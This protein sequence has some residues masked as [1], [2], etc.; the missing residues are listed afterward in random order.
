MKVSPIRFVRSSRS[1][2]KNQAGSFK[3]SSIPN[4][5]QEETQDKK[6][7]KVKK[8][9]NSIPKSILLVSS[10]ALG[11]LGGYLLANKKGGQANINKIAKEQENTWLA[12]LALGGIAGYE[13]KKLSK[14]D[15]EE[16]IEKFQTEQTPLQ[17]SINAIK[18]KNEKLSDG[19]INPAVFKY[20]KE[21]HGL[22]LLTQDNV[23]NKNSQKYDKAIEEIKNVAFEKLTS[24]EPL[25]PLEKQNPVFWSATSEFAPVKEGGL[26]SVPPE[27]RSNLAKLDIQMPTFIPMYLNEGNSTFSKTDEGYFYNYKGKTIPLEKVATLKLDAYKNSKMQ[28]VPVEFYLSEEETPNGATKQ[29]IFIKSDKYFD[30]TIYEANLKTEEPEKFAIMSKAIYEFAK[31]KTDGL[32]ASKDV[33]INSKEAFDKI[34]APDGFILND[35]QASPL[36]ALLRY[37][38]PMENAYGALSDETSKNLSSSRIITIGHNIAYQGSTQSNND[39]YQKNLATSNVLNT[40]FDKYSYDIVSNAKIQVDKID[41]EDENLKNIDN[42]LLM[43]KNNPAATSTNFLNMGIILSD[44]FHP[45]SKNYAKE[46]ISPNHPELSN[47]LQWA[48]IQKEKA[49]KLIGI[50]NGND[51]ENLSIEANLGKIKKLTGLDFEPYTKETPI[52]NLINSRT[53]N[54]MNMYY[55]FV[56][57]FSDSSASSE[58]QKAQAKAVSSRLEFVQGKQGTTL[59]ILSQ[60]ELFDTPIFT[61]GGR[62]VSQKGIDVLCDAIKILFDNWDKDFPNQN[63]PIFYIAGADG[64]QGIQREI[65]EK[66]KDETLSKED[67]DRILFAHGF[68]PMAAMMAG[69]D[70]FLMPSKFE[71]CGL[72]QGESLALATPVIASSVGGIVDTVNRNNKTN[73]ILTKQEDSLTP[74]AFYEAMKEGLNIYFNDKE[75]YYSMVQNSLDEDFSWIQKGKQGPVFEYLEAL[76]INKDNLKEIK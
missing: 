48:L 62:L 50:I 69:S 20:S 17:T 15:K 10:L 21:Y 73:G 5:K 42:V 41:K 76:G 60:S 37:K 29:L 70:F 66:L 39:Y 2:A 56:L 46:L 4:F 71:P 44:Y 16:V 7:G 52:E 40:L 25:K 12:L 47:S 34:K 43:D 24:V 72:T 3:G 35:W 68:A 31:I 36:A 38:A 74:E 65:I 32:K 53:K 14:K 28:S 19:R 8:F 58:E 63:K 27:I 67:N 61:S 55:N 75:K 6:E 11:A 13:G 26:G 54:K 51:F 49:G 45:V 18:Q 64:E 59:P 9:F 23:M 30:G 57:P 33:E 1:I 22:S